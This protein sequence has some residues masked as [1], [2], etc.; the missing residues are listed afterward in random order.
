MIYILFVFWTLNLKLYST[1]GK[2]NYQQFETIFALD[3]W[4]WQIICL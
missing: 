2:W 4:N 3:D 1:L